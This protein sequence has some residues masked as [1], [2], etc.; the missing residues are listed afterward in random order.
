MNHRGWRT[1]RGLEAELVRHYGR[2]WW[3]STA[4]FWLWATTVLLPSFVG[5]FLWN[6]A[7]VRSPLRYAWFWLLFVSIMIP[8][9]SIA[10]MLCLASSAAGTR[11]ERWIGQ[12]FTWLVTV[13]AAAFIAIEVVAI[14]EPLVVPRHAR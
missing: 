11:H 12:R 1:F 5:L 4:R 6:P 9:G 13:F 7:I 8:S 10:T 14:A 2:T 3:A